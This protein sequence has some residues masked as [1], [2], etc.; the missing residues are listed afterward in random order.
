MSELERYISDLKQKLTGASLVITGEKPLAYGIQITVGEGKAGV[1]VNIYS[2]KKGISV[3]VGGSD[4]SPLKSAVRAVIDG[5]PIVSES[6]PEMTPDE[7]GL[8]PGF[9]TV[10][11][12]DYRWIGTDESGKGDFF[13]PLV[14]AGVRVDKDTADKLAAIGVKDSKALTDAKAQALAAQIR[15]IC[16]D[17]FSE[18]E[19]NPARYNSLYDQFRAEG[20]NLNHLLAWAHARVLEDILEKGPCRFAL[21]DKFADERFILSRLMA[22]G[23]QLVLVQTPRAE[24]NVAV[25]AASILARDRFLARMDDQR[26]RYGMELPKG[27]S[28][29]VVD[30]ARAFAAKYG[31]QALVEV[32]KVHFKTIDQI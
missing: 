15:T 25:A 26:A 13:G 12:F 6:S 18:L 23:R 11:D 19:M 4:G 16:P 14:V 29:K 3:V 2:G 8:P 28:A 32:A 21:A 24:R 7:P 30:A 22:K 5:R 10:A 17:A 27:A 1:P 9:E 20:K 31:K